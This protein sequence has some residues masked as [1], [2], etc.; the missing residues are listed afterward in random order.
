MTVTGAEFP[1]MDCLL[2]GAIRC[3]KTAFSEHLAT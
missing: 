2:G 3:W 1:F